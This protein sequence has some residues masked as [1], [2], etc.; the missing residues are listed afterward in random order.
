MAAK[1]AKTAAEEARIADEN[2]SKQGKIPVEQGI[3]EEYASVID[4]NGKIPMRA[5]MH[6]VSDNLKPPRRRV[7]KRVIGT[8]Q[9]V[10]LI[11]TLFSMQN[12][13]Y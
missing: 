4:N 1:Q 9:L 11:L 10:V 13:I 6:G 7:K 5:G 3:H 2:A 12:H 8:H